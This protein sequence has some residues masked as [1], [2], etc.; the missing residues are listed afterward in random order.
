MFILGSFEKCAPRT[1]DT[2]FGWAN[3]ENTA[4][5]SSQSFFL[6]VPNGFVPSFSS[7]FVKFSKYDQTYFFRVESENVLR[8]RIKMLGY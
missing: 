3:A 2:A 6:S 5:Y 8:M 4:T 1:S 7:S